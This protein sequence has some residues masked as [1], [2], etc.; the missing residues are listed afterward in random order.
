MN[1][2]LVLKRDAKWSDL[3]E[4]L[5]QGFELEHGPVVI[6]CEDIGTALAIQ[7]GIYSNCGEFRYNAQDAT[8][9]FLREHNLPPGIFY[10]EPISDR[11][12]RFFERLVYKPI[13]YFQRLEI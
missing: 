8:Q 10:M 7:F 4:L 1:Q 9:D 6:E 13:I 3:G 5:R 11:V 12:S 2:N